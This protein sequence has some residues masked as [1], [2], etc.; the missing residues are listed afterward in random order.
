MVFLLLEHQ[1]ASDCE[2]GIHVGGEDGLGRLRCQA[3]HLTLPLPSG[4]LRSIFA[5]SSPDQEGPELGIGCR[6]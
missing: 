2:R 3:T 5:V 6:R 4:G 1:F